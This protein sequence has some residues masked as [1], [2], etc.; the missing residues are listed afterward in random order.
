MVFPEG[1]EGL[2][3]Y[4]VWLQAIE[5][6]TIE[7]TG[8]TEVVG[9]FLYLKGED[10][11][12]GEDGKSAYEIWVEAV[13]E[14]LDNPKNP[15]TEWPKDQTDLS[16]FWYYLTG[17][18]G[19]DGVTPNIGENGNWWINGEDTGIPATGEDGEDGH[20]P[21]ITIGSNGNW[22]IDGVDT[23]QAAQG[24]KGDTGSS[25]SSGSA[26]AT[27]ATG[28]SAYELW[29][30]QVKKGL[31]TKVD[32][33]GNE[34]TWTEAMGTSIKDFWRYLTGNDG[35]DGEDGDIIP[36]PVPAEGEYNVI[37]EMSN[38][39]R[40]EYVRWLDGKVK[41]TVYN[42][43]NPLPNA[44]VKFLSYDMADTF[45]ADENGVFYVENS[46]L[47]QKENTKTY[48]KALVN[49]EH[50]TAQKTYVPCQ[51]QIRLVLNGT[52]HLEYNLLYY[53]PHDLSGVVIPFVIQRKEDTASS[54]DKIPSYL[55]GETYRV[56]IYE[57]DTNGN[58]GEP[59]EGDKEYTINADSLS[60]TR[61]IIS[62]RDG[63][64][65]AD[66][67]V[68]EESTTPSGSTIKYWGE[69]K[70]STTTPKKYYTIGFGLGAETGFYGEKLRL[71]SSED[72]TTYVAIEDL[73]LQ[74]YPI[75][76]H[77]RIADYSTS[78]DKKEV[79]AFRPY[80]RVEDPEKKYWE[81]LLCSKAGFI[82]DSS[83]AVN[84]YT[85][86]V[87]Q[88]NSNMA[89]DYPYL[90]IYSIYLYGG[91]EGQ[92]GTVGQVLGKLNEEFSL[93]SDSHI[94]NQSPDGLDLYTNTGDW[95]LS[96]INFYKTYFGNHMKMNENK[97]VTFDNYYKS[98]YGSDDILTRV[99][100]IEQH[101]DA[102][103]E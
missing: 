3:A 16:D 32:A 37:A 71:V 64:F 41:Y 48:I 20:S 70:G 93:D 97:V 92:A 75:P 8:S 35:E 77:I 85:T 5:D 57:L 47:P 66:K 28:Q 10:G 34:Y 22:F 42:G 69:Y 63:A 88:R 39:E 27:G 54:W 100:K 98:K 101:S 90:P 36:Q 73:P 99:P 25:G 17:A 1:P 65:I 50:E 33:D 14:G 26:G 81:D 102:Q 51:M 55:T 29:V 6:G 79:R 40:G 74:P 61:K 87:A 19:E 56:Q 38:A 60:I 21:V 72:N 52:P 2:S 7:W 62:S 30:E 11:E 12:D 78:N 18:D 9:F 24:P 13:E 58:L 46:K 96:T 31:V 23:G 91:N 84:G 83:N 68:E 89:D 86:Y 80:F 44:T 76:T 53:H 103:S 95:A 94:T 67:Y 59:E 4:E 82:I 43:M 45:T 49:D 15:G